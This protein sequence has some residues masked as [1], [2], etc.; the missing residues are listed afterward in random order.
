MITILRYEQS[1]KAVWDQ[2]IDDSKNGTFMLKRDY[3][4]YHADRFMDYSLM[5][6]NENKIV[7]L[8]PASVHDLEV[9]SHGGLTYG[10][11]VINRKATTQLLLEVFDA[12]LNYLKKDNK[13]TLIYKRIP[14]IYYNYPSDEDLYAL[15]MHNAHLKKLT[16]SSTVYLKDRINFNE[17]RRRNI[18]KA[19]K[20]GL[21][22]KQSDDYEQYILMLSEVLASRHETKPVHSSDELIRLASLFPENIKLFAAFDS[23]DVML[24]GTVIYETPSVAHAQYIAS[25][26]DG[27]S[28]GALDL[29]FDILINDKYKDKKYFDFGISNEADGRVLNEGLI[30]QK[31]EFGGRGI[32][33]D[34]YI[35]NF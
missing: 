33:Y 10:G 19:V 14:Q 18:K 20:A 35:L 4:E 32:I 11:I 5:F 24:A 28:C 6:Y 9:R 30:T 16:I 29:V 7:A 13:D 26:A 17:R 22:V 21:V 8:L 3:M 1:Y 25:S 23:N 2:F 34:E 31:Q 15:F 12:L 27:R